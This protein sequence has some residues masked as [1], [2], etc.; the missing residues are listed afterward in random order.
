MRV[1]S[2]D[3]GYTT[4]IAVYGSDSEL[5]ASMAVTRR[6]LFKNGFLNHLVSIAKPDVVLIEALPQNLVSSEM[7]KIHGYITTWFTVAGM[8]PISIR[9]SQWKGLVERVEIPGV[10]ARD[11]ATMAKWWVLKEGKANE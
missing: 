4:G 6:G 11:A 9:P 8:T 7:Q 2:I 3:P 10:H 1:L 5:E